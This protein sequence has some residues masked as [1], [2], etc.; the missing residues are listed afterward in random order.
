MYRLGNSYTRF[1]W[2]KCLHLQGRIQAMHAPLD[3]QG[4]GTTNCRYVDKFWQSS[5]AQLATT[6]E[7]SVEGAVRGRTNG[8]GAQGL[9]SPAVEKWKWQ[10][11]CS[12]LSR[13]VVKLSNGVYFDFPHTIMQLLTVPP[14][15]SHDWSHQQFFHPTAKLLNAK[16]RNL[17]LMNSSKAPSQENI[18]T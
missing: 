11:S 5:T 7:F 16:E 9:D 12:T 4:E 17:A 6:F 14:L 10:N 3:S 15:S 2:E 8:T 1:K 13:T 18:R